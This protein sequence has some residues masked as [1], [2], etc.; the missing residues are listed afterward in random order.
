MSKSSRAS[1][2]TSLTFAWE[3]SRMA[4]ETPRQP[5]E[6]SLIEDAAKAS[7]LSVKKLAANAG[8]SDTRWRHI[9][10][11]YQPAPN[12]TVNPV[13]APANTLAKMALAVDVTP[14]ELA[15]TGRTDAADLLA[16]MKAGA[17]AVT[18]TGAV[19]GV[20]VMDSGA[21]EIDLIY[22]SISMSAEQKLKAIRQVL[23]LRAQADAEAARRKTPAADA[24]ASMEP[25]G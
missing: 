23:H 12:G 10:R 19:R 25:Q 22:E 2:W 7:G 24:E 15:K 14:E 21:D 8:I 4:H 9:V 17:G 11:G 16:R 6:G 13:T 3:H 5:R 18:T 1:S 20:G